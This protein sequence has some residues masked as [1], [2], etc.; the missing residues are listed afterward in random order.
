M[1]AFVRWELTAPRCRCCGCR[2]SATA[3]SRSTTSSLLLMS[4]VFVPFF[5]FASVYA[6]VS[7]AK[8]PPKPGV[9]LLYFFIGFVVLAQIGGRILDRRGARPAVV[10]GSAI[11]AV[12]FYLLAESSPTCRCAPRNGHPPRRRR[13]RPDARAGQHRRRQPRPEHQLQRGHGDHPDGRATSARASASRSSGRSCSPRQQR[14]RQ[15]A[16][17]P[18][19]PGAPRRTHRLTGRARAA[20]AR[21]AGAPSPTTRSGSPP[22]TR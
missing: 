20:P 3:A 18:W 4:F 21:A 8:T 10:L 22:R 17:R 19:G 6:Q 1:V 2:S 15:G 12:G 11:G 9:Y 13:D 16:D 7:L 5:F 14:G